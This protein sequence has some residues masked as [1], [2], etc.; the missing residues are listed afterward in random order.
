MKRVNLIPEILF[1]SLFITVM[2]TACQKRD[3]LTPEPD[4]YESQM[5]I[6]SV[7]GTPFNFNL[8]EKNKT[9]VLGTME[10]SNDRDNVYV[11]LAASAENVFAR[12]VLTLA[13]NIGFDNYDILFGNSNE[14]LQN[15]VVAAGISS[16]GVFCNNSS[17]AILKC[18]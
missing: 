8:I 9:D 17:T 1:I 7:C 18:P 12:Q 4:R 2:F 15:L 16:D 5:K 13:L 14:Q 11:K 3:N 6:S 10:I